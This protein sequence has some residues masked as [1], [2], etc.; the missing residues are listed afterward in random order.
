[1]KLAR[2]VCVSFTLLLL[3]WHGALLGACKEESFASRFVRPAYAATPD[4]TLHYFGHSFFQ[5]VTSRGTRIVMDPLAPGWYPVPDVSAHAVT[6]GREHQ[7]HNWFP[8]VKGRPLLL[9]G[10]RETDLGYE[11][12][13]VRTTV[14]DVLVYS[15]PIYVSRPNGNL[16]KGAAFAYDLGRLCVVHLGDL[17]HK[18]TPGHLKQFGKVDVALVPIGGRTTMGPWTAREVIGQLKPKMAI[19]M[20]YRDDLERVRIFSEGFP[21]RTVPDGSLA[22]SKA[23]LPRKT[24]IVV[25]GYRGGPF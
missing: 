10:L 11:W 17:S 12:N 3:F 1:M 24:E 21:T 9:R 7:N 5:L 13:P 25:L 4:A 22:I 2:L 15:V 8:I 16:F 23:A 20:H 19:P 6:I 14:L 18:L